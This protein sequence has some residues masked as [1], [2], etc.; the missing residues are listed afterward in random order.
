MVKNPVL[1]L[2]ICDIARF[3]KHTKNRLAEQNILTVE[4]L[5]QRTESE[6]LRFPNLGRRS[7]NSIKQFLA[8]HNLRLGLTD[9]SETAE[10]STK[11]YEGECLRKITF[12]I[13]KQ[14][15]TFMEV[16]P[17]IFFLIKK[18]IDE[19]GESMDKKEAKEIY[20]ILI[21]ISAKA[22]LQPLEYGVGPMITRVVAILEKP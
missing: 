18:R 17:E 7:V 5:A 6:L 19:A 15:I 8:L 16:L 21:G 10:I 14:S 20:D 1:E 4:D 2:K 9:L 13:L 3:T 11:K 22:K 12:Y